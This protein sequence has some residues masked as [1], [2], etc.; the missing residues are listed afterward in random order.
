MEDLHEV[1]ITLKSMDDLE[2]FYNDIETDGGND[3]IPARAVPVFKRRPISRNT[4]YMLTHDE[5][6][7]IMEDPRVDGV[8]FAK[9]AAAA[10]KPMWTTPSQDFS[11]SDESVSNHYNWGLKRCIDGVQTPNWG[12][13]TGCVLS[14]IVSVSHSLSGKHVDVIIVDG[15]IDASHPEFAV[16]ADGTGGSRVNQFNWFSLNSIVTSIDDD[17]STLGTGTYTY[18]WSGAYGSNIV[19]QSNHGCHVAGIAAG[20]TAGWARDANIYNISPYSTNTNTLDSLALWDYIRAFH[21]NKSINPE[22][23]HKNPTIC[24]CSYGSSITWPDAT[25][26]T[27]SITQVV[28]R[29]VTTGNRVS[30]LSQTQLRTAKIQNTSG[31]ATIPYYDSSEVADIQQAIDDGII[32]VGA[33]GNDS[34]YIDDQTGLDY[35]NYF[36]AKYN[37]VNYTW[38]AHRGSA[39]GSASNVITV[40]S[41]ANAANE[42]KA[43]FSNTGPGITVFAPGSSIS[44]SYNVSDTYSNTTDPRNAS[45]VKGK[46]SGTSMASPQVTGVLACALEMY[47]NMTQADAVKYIE[48]FSKLDQIPLY[49]SVLGPSFGI[50][51]LLNLVGAPNRYLYAHKERSVTNR[52]Y[53]K[54][55]YWLRPTSGQVYPR[56]KR[57]LYK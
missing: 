32:I 10:I 27:G 21:R 33:A 18:T 28:I 24:N 22:T 14:N 43:S 26:G 53:P 49:D 19:K 4:H 51:D 1:I 15:H 55:N 30:A 47:P 9:L 13:G 16:N 25:I 57:R 54:I 56:V 40:G 8:T 48:T 2:S 38:D 52:V 29:N 44:S 35:N 41:I 50:S 42:A 6:A 36:W 37:G 23:G 39:P 34:A 3:T 11:K 31:I 46:I 5:V 17:A 12:Y 45:Y 7:I 20:N